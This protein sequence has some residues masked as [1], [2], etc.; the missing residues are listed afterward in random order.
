MK[1]TIFYAALL[2]VGLHIHYLFREGIVYLPKSTNISLIANQKFY[3]TENEVN[4]FEGVK[5]RLAVFNSR[6][7]G[8]KW[9]NNRNTISF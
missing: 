6:K 5:E 3:T 1:I 4:S 2:F 9:H 7:P 8:K